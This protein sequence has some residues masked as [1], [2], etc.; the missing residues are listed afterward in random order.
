MTQGYKLSAITFEEEVM[1]PLY[2][3]IA[4]LAQVQDQDLS[5]W[6]DV[7]TTIAEPPGLVSFFRYF[8]GD[9]SAKSKE[10]MVILLI[11]L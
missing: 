1:V 8:Y 11:L 7:N 5:D 4:D 10:L 2:T 6:V 3:E 9:N